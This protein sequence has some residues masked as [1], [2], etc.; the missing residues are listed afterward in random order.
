MDKFG[1][2]QPVRRLEDER[3]LTGQGRYIDDARPRGRFMA[4][5]VR[6]QVAH[7]AVERRW[8]CPR[9]ARCRGSSW[10]WR[11]RG[12]WGSTISLRDEVVTNR[13]GS[14]GGQAARS[15]AGNRQGAFRGRGGGHVIVLPRR[16]S[17]P[18]MRPRW[19]IPMTD[20]CPRRSIWPP[21]VS[22]SMHGGARQ[23]G[24]R[25]GRQG[26]R[27]EAVARRAIARARRMW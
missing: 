22:R 27:H 15:G 19:S 1:K 14:K 6:S 13:D 8:T 3:F 18:R 23:S 11:P 25:L 20:D 12:R 16:G 9:C 10:R 26:R 21:A 17:R 5:F 2:S 4:V 7:G 24:L